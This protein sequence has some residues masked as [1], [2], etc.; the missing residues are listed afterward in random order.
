MP[1]LL[2]SACG[3]GAS[4]DWSINAIA[5]PN[6]EIEPVLVTSRVGVGESRLAF[7]LFDRERNLIDGATDGELHLY[8][9]DGDAGTL[10]G[11]HELR[12]A[13]LTGEGTPHAHAD[14]DTHLHE[15][16]TT[17]GYASTV[18]LTRPG[19]WGAELRFRLD[20]R[21]LQLRYRFSI[22]ESTDEPAVG[23]PV[24]PSRQ[25]LLSDVDDIALVDTSVAPVPELH[26]LTIAEAIASGR[27]SV[28]AF[29]TPLFCQT[30]FCGPV[31]EQIVVPV[32]ERYNDRVNVLQVEP[33]E[34][35]AARGGTLVPVEAMLEWRLQTEPWVFVLNADGL[36]VAKFE[37]I[38]GLDEVVEAV[39]RALRE[40]S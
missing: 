40:A 4:D 22:A 18:Q 12:A 33:Y 28:I 21:D 38:M 27:P 30:R 13:R 23:E 35:P 17:T 29:A 32:W 20:G 16:P 39:E 5:D 8:S 37:G 26:E 34:V 24:P 15:G 6:A 14:G 1:A 11:E 3:G 19:W 10:E 31:V 2:L 36:V 7:A 9:I 25:L